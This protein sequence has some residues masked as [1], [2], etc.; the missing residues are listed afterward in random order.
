MNEQ[1]NVAWE[2][3]QMKVRMLKEMERD[4]HDRIQK[5]YVKH[6]EINQKPANQ[7]KSDQHKASEFNI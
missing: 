3:I 7:P 1:M 6:S 2:Q 5:L 4:K